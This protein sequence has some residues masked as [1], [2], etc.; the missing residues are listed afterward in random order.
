MINARRSFSAVVALV[1]TAA[2]ATAFVQTSSMR[3]VMANDVVCRQ[4]PSSSSTAIS[5]HQLGEILI[6]RMQADTAGDVWHQYAPRSVGC[7]IH[8][9]LT[10][11]A[12]DRHAAL[13]AA[14]DRILTRSDSAPLEDYVA[15]DNLL[16]STPTHAHS[17]S[18]ILD[19]S[20]LL[21]LRRFQLL[22]R[23]GRVETG[24]S[25]RR[26][27][28]KTAWFFSYRDTL[29]YHEPWGRWTVTA[30]MFWALYE[31]HANTP[32]AEEIAWSA[33]RATVPGDEC[34]AFC[35]LD[36]LRRTYVRYLTLFPRGQW[37]PEALRRAEESTAAAAR[38]GCVYTNAAT[39][40]ELVSSLRRAV[41]SLPE[42]SRSALNAHL[43]NV[44][45]VCQ[46][47]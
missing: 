12:A 38:V 2:G 33:A 26:D 5:T 10:S 25:V 3:M 16:R 39:T 24:R 14:T 1:G 36:A 29:R 20:A 15:V 45:R 11:D 4:Q 17:D 37:A 27:P 28:L 34:D 47:E 6:P 32:A 30:E 46:R 42:A 31:R 22:E 44:E 40:R 8:A 41:T 9:S 13:L 23:A 18:T 21:Q 35:W 19:T 7:W 43:A